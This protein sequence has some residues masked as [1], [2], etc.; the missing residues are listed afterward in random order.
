MYGDQHWQALQ[1]IKRLQA[2][3]MALAEIARELVGDA[4]PEA[5]VPAAAPL[6]QYEIAKDVTV[7]VSA[8]ASP[9]RLK[10]IRT[11]LAELAAHLKEQEETTNE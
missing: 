11:A 8:D 5:P 4:A 9:W 3:G 2:K 1:R 10:Q 7:L 6:W